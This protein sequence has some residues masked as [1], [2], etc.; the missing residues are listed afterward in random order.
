M[1]VVCV[2][3][4]K[5]DNFKVQLCAFVNPLRFIGVSVHLVDEVH[6]ANGYWSDGWLTLFIMHFMGEAARQTLLA[7]EM[8]QGFSGMITLQV[9]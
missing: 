4:E 6:C 2:E 1:D 8:L 3:E 7:Q 9:L 5:G